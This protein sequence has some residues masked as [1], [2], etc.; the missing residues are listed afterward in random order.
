MVVDKDLDDLMQTKVC[1]ILNTA[2][3]FKV[4][5]EKVFQAI[6]AA[7]DLIKN[8]EKVNLTIWDSK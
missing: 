8:G 4:T 2:D 3:L 7:I 1:Q 5:P 6:I